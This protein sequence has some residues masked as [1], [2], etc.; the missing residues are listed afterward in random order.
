VGTGFPSENA[1]T[2][3]GRQSAGREAHGMTI[4]LLTIDH[5]SDKIGQAFVVEQ[6]DAPAIA[7]TLTEAKPLRNFANAPR[8]PFSLVFIAKGDSALPQR[9]YALRHA[10]LG[11]QSIFLV[12]IGKDGDTVSYEAVFN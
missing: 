3:Q 2:Q 12:P 9:M 10:A 11:L 8:A 6:A 4:E 1:I 5:F 7:L